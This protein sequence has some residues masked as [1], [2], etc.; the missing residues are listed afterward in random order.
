MS[1]DV[2]AKSPC[3]ISRAAASWLT[4]RGLVFL[5]AQRRGRH[6]ADGI[7]AQSDSPQQI[8]YDRLRESPMA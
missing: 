2:P 5:S 4:G 3:A 8:L 1:A 6:L 7:G